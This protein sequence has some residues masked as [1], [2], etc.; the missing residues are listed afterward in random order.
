MSYSPPRDDDNPFVLQL[1]APGPS[2]RYCKLWSVPIFETGDNIVP[3]DWRDYAVAVHETSD[4]AL[5]VVHAHHQGRMP[6][7]DALQYICAVPGPAAPPRRP[8]RGA[9]LVTVGAA[10]AAAVPAYA[11]VTATATV[12]HLFELPGGPGRPVTAAVMLYNGAQLSFVQFALGVPAGE[13]GWVTAA[14]TAELG[15]AETASWRAEVQEVRKKL[16]WRACWRWRAG[17]G[18]AED[19]PG[20]WL[21]RE[22][23][24]DLHSLEFVES[25]WHA[26]EECGD[27]VEVAVRMPALCFDD[28]AGLQAAVRQRNVTSSRLTGYDCGYAVEMADGTVATSGAGPARWGPAPAASV[29]PDL[30]Q[31]GVVATMELHI[32]RDGAAWFND[33]EAIEFK[34]HVPI[35]SGLAHFLGEGGPARPPPAPKDAWTTRRWHP[36]MP[37]ALDNVWITNTGTSM[38]E[39]A[40]PWFPLALRRRRAPAV[41]SP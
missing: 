29:S 33:T 24:A 12:L 17:M 41:P 36:E 21:T 15:P 1:W 27:P 23:A 2:G 4:S 3:S 26:G 30:G 10:A 5:L 25:A 35:A 37:F 7:G 11:P 39:I 31:G 13:A 22:E 20:P 9:R 32:M 19:A 34:V 6:W 8:V 40:H 28:D 18:D 16:G 14:A 38:V